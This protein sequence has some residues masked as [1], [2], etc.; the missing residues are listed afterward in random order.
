MAAAE[1]GG[2]P[3]RFNPSRPSV[4]GPPAPGSLPNAPA[5]G[6]GNPYGVGEP[7]PPGPPEFAYGPGGPGGDF[8]YAGMEGLFAA[9]AE[10]MGVDQERARAVFNRY[11]QEYGQGK[12]IERPLIEED[13]W[14][15]GA[16][17]MDPN[18]PRTFGR[19]ARDARQL[20]ADR[21]AVLKQLEASGLQGGELEAAKASAIANLYGGLADRRSAAIDEARNRLY[22]VARDKTMG[23]S[24]GEDSG[25]A[26]AM[27]GYFGNRYNTDVGAAT[28]RYGID[29]NKDLAVWNGMRDWM[30]QKYGIDIGAAT[31]YRGQTLSDEASR[32]NYELERERLA[33]EK[34]RG[35]NSLVG[36]LVG[37]LGAAAGTAIGGP[38]GGAIGARIGGRVGG[39][40]AI[41][42][43]AFSG[44]RASGSANALDR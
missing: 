9:L 8:P 34:K 39:R 15:M 42:D 41:D 14:V 22:G 44:S 27:L 40:Q 13:Q 25:S 20:A 26:Q 29:V 30:M 37:T 12:A 24:P 3:S 1:Y 18:D 7:A 38:V 32:R 23:F 4:Y 36:A 17:G 6:P 2:T 16:G 33:I 21:D 10:R 35:K 19:Y 28:Q 31:A 5:A 11:M 43:A